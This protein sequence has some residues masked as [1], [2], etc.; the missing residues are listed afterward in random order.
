MSNI[1]LEIYFEKTFTNS[2]QFM[3]ENNDINQDDHLW[4]G[5]QIPS[6][7]NSRNILVKC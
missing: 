7:N 4:I 3:F 2:N 1:N 6:H 5:T